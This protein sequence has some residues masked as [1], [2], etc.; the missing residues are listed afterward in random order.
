MVSLS[1]WIDVRIWSVEWT[2]GSPSKR[3]L[4]RKDGF[5]MRYFE[6]SGLAYGLGLRIWFRATN[7]C[8]VPRRPQFPFPLVWSVYRSGA[9]RR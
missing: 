5:P 4:Q 9:I 7:E 8:F 3:V 2:K 6:F 1:V